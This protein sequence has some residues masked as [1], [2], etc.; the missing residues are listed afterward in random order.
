MKLLRVAAATLVVLASL[1]AWSPGAGAD[2]AVF[3]GAC[4]FNNSLTATFTPSLTAVP[5]AHTFT[6]SGASSGACTGNIPGASMTI[7]GNANS[8]LYG[9]HEGVAVGAATVSFSGGFVDSYEVSPLVIVNTGGVITIAGKT[10]VSDFAILGTFVQSPTDTLKCTTG[11][12][13]Q[14]HW[15][16]AVVFGD[17]PPPSA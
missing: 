14:G 8:A 11:T 17:P 3:F 4:V 16:G 12:L 1:L 7:I 6:L 15:T 5:A 13:S 9:C 10:Q 2:G